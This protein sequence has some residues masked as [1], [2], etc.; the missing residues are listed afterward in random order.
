ML[1]KHDKFSFIAWKNNEHYLRM[2]RLRCLS[3]TCFQLSSFLLQIILIIFKKR[4]VVFLSKIYYIHFCFSYF[5]LLIWFNRSFTVMACIFI[6]LFIKK[7]LS[8]F[9]ELQMGGISL[10]VALLVIR[11]T[12]QDW[13]VRQLMGRWGSVPFASASGYL[14][15]EPTWQLLWFTSRT[16]LPS[17]Q[18]GTSQ[19]NLW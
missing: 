16:T 5:Q 19:P 13:S 2:F 9:N 11:T 10:L 18:A 8:L 3:N 15:T 7:K 6:V 12:Q 17:L 1:R 4:H 14:P